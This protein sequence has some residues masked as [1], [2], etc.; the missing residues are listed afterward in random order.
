MVDLIPEEYRQTRRLS[1]LLRG[2]GWT[3]CGMAAVIAATAAGV[4]YLVKD[5]RVALARFQ[6]LQAQGRAQRARLTELTA[7]RNEAQKQLQA[8]DALRG[9]ASIGQLVA[10]LDAA[11]NE[12][13]WFQ[14]LAF[15]RGGDVIDRKAESAGAGYF[16]VAPKDK[17]PEDKGEEN[18]WRAQERAEVRGLAGDHAVL[19]EFIKQLGAQPEVRQVR[20]LDTSAR[21]YPNVEVVDFQ[22]T[23]LL[24]PAPGTAR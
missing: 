5:E 2:F 4:A 16:V 18:G 15:R 22:L 21:N 3:C 12:R 10:A 23:A 14:E 17:R 1:R 8:L 6:Q 7:R 11:L 9:G 20:L 19:A 13:I 24:G